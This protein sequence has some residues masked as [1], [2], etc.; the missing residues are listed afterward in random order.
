M[1]GPTSAN[2]ARVDDAWGSLQWESDEYTN[3]KKTFQRP[4]TIAR[5]LQ[6]ERPTKKAVA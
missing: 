6:R 4:L 2:Q 3:E 1:G 5:S